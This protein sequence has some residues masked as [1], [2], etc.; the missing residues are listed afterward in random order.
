MPIEL[1]IKLRT[2]DLE[3][4][5]EQLRAGGA[6]RVR[7]GLE[8]NLIYD[9][10]DGSLRAAGTGLRL[11]TFRPDEGEPTPAT[12]TYKGPREAGPMKR[13][14]EI[15][16]HTEDTAEAKVMLERLGFTTVLQYEKRREI[17]QCG[18]CEVVLDEVP[19]LGCF[20]EIEGPD[21]AAI[22]QVRDDLGW[23]QLI[24]EPRSYV[25]LVLEH[26]AAYGIEPPVLRFP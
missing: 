5:R 2:P 20:L 22:E 7:S 11:R 9:R 8:W 21:E 25:A 6:E 18:G 17:W 10:P 19:H 1:E 26:C 12:L 13:R 16:L 14:E 24:V 3:A 4:A 15:E 23:T